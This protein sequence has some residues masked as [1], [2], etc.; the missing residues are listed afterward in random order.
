MPA[1]DFES[2]K[3]SAIADGNDPCGKAYYQS[4]SLDKHSAHVDCTADTGKTYYI[5]GNW[6]DY[7]SSFRGNLIVRGNLTFS[8]GSLP[9]LSAYDAVVPTTS[10]KQYCNDWAYYRS[11]FDSAPAASPA[12]FGDINNEYRAV[13]V[14]KSITPAMRGF[15]YVGGNLTLPN[16]GGSSDLLH[17]VIIVN[18]T[19]DINSNSHCKVYY[20]PDTSATIRTNKVYL[21][22][23]SWVDSTQAWP[24]P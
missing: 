9:T 21:V 12:C 23:T 8:N 1:I 18:G 6:T 14:T 22:R 11:N 4:G 10:W 15:V 19:A 16:G 2:Y 17:G 5:A 20:N 13:G 3:S 24:L 7:D